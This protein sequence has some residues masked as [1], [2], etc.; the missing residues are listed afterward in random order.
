MCPDFP[1]FFPSAAVL[2]RHSREPASQAGAGACP[3]P[4]GESLNG[5]V[6]QRKLGGGDDG[7]W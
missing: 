1:M 7:K 6:Y 5:W 4:F 2:T 3:S